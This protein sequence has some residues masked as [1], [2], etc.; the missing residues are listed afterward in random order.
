MF[1]LFDSVLITFLLFLDLSALF[2]HTVKC[3]D[4]AVLIVLEP[5]V[6]DVLIDSPLFEIL[7][8]PIKFNARTNYISVMRLTFFN[9]L[10]P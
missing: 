8:S 3:V 10:Q 1:E 2:S 9:I 7:Q 4:Q 5:Q 6:D